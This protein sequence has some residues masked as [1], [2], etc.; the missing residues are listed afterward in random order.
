[1]SLAVIGCVST[2]LQSYTA[3]AAVA[4]WKFLPALPNAASA[5]P[6]SCMHV[7]S[8][9]NV[10]EECAGCVTTKPLSVGPCSLPNSQ[11][12]PLATC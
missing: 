6:E 2:V 9:M 11:P 12:H 4:T 8:S 7:G 10:C 1:M 5:Q 3:S